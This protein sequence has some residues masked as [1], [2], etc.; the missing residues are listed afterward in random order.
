MGG[1]DYIHPHTMDTTLPSFV[2]N[3]WEVVVLRRWVELYG[4]CDLIAN[5]CPDQT[6]RARRVQNGSKHANS[7]TELQMMLFGKQHF[8]PNIWGLWPNP[9]IGGRDR[10]YTQMKMLQNISKTLQ[11]LSLSSR[12]PLEIKNAPV[13]GLC[14]IFLPFHPSFHGLAPVGVQCSS[15]DRSPLC[16]VNRLPLNTELI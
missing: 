3:F 10:V 7:H 9:K 16:S 11:A 15:D 1:G 5:A 4:W 8:L 12:L 6:R 13:I 2:H 14:Q